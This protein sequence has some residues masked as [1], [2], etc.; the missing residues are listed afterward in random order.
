M[1]HLAGE[2][3]G[4]LVPSHCIASI[5]RLRKQVVWRWGSWPLWTGS[6][7]GPEMARPSFRWESWRGWWWA[8]GV[9]QVRTLTYLGRAGCSPR[10][11]PCSKMIISYLREFFLLHKTWEYRGAFWMHNIFIF[12]LPSASIT[13]GEMN[14]TIDEYFQSSIKQA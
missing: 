7:T 8:P 14:N 10:P 3:P 1:F 2:A 4:H 6:T 13:K 9:R 11:C 12:P 5:S